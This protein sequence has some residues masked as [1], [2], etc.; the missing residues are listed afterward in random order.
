MLKEELTVIDDLD[1]KESKDY[2]SILQFC[3]LSNIRV[4]AGKQSKLFNPQVE[5]TEQ[6]IWF[7]DEQ[8][9]ITDLLFR[10]NKLIRKT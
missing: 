10:E 8:V 3:M 1:S 9:E 6:W 4:F 2:H 7:E 5:L